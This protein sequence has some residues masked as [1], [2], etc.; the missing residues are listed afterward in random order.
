[1]ILS[2]FRNAIQEIFETAINGTGLATVQIIWEGE[3]GPRLPP[4]YLSMEV[5]GNNPLGMPHQGP[6]KVTQAK[7]GGTQTITQSIDRTVSIQGFGNST[8]Y[9][10]EML[11]DSFDKSAT[12]SALRSK[13]LSIR[14]V[15]DI[16][17]IS[18]V[19]DSDME[20][21]WAVDI[22]VGDTRVVVDDP[23]YIETVEIES[24]IVP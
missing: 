14:D 9:R 12:I 3:N 13:G 23:G 18:A 5:L 17:D 24:T 20:S 6:V 11:V 15:G 19:V 4:P 16:R 21:R 10:L 2:E 8:E 7:P 22:V 1:M